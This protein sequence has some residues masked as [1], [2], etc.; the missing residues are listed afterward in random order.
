[1][2]TFDECNGIS[3]TVWGCPKARIRLFCVFMAP[4][5]ENGVHLPTKFA[6]ENH[7]QSQ[8]GQKMIEQISLS[9]H[10]H[11]VSARAKGWFCMNKSELR[12][13]R[14][15]I[16][17]NNSYPNVK[18]H[19]RR[20]CYQQWFS[21]ILWQLQLPYLVLLL[22]KQGGVGFNSRSHFST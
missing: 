6:K 13:A 9:N 16:Q 4:W 11:W 19:S 3:G 15:S 20:C 14:L 18:P 12:A 7:H 17:W 5:D 22:L 21:V 2:V 1:M 8:S 10:Y